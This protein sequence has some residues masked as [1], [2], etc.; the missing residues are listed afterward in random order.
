[1]TSP[2]LNFLDAGAPI[3]SPEAGWLRGSGA[4]PIESEGAVTV[5]RVDGTLDPAGCGAENAPLRAVPG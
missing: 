1:M 5:W 4:E 2:F 3:S